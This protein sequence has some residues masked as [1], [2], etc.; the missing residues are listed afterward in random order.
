MKKII[1]LATYKMAKTAYFLKERLEHE[2][3]NC[4]LSY[5]TNL[6]KNRDEVRVQ[7]EDDDVER[8]IKTM[9]RIKD[10]YGKDIEMIEPVE[11]IR[12]IVVPTDFSKES[13]NAC[14]Y[15]LYLARKLRAEIKI[16]HVYENPIDDV[17]VRKSSSFE[18]Y[19]EKVSMEVEEDARDGLQ[20]FSQRIRDY[21]SASRIQDVK[22][23]SSLVMGNIVKKIGG[24]CQVYAPDFVVLGIAGKERGSKN[25]VAGL[26]DMLIRDLRIP[27]YAIPGPSEKKDLDQMNIL[28]A[29]D[30]NEQDH[31][32]LNQ[33]L[34]LMEPFNIRID[35]IHI[36]V[37]QNPV[38]EMRMNELN[39]FLSE[40]YS[41]QDIQCYL[42]EDEDVYHGIKVFAEN[43]GINLLSFT[44]H[45]RRIFEKLFKPNL[46]K[47]M[48]HEAS[49]PILIFPS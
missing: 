17:S 49:I 5:V 11:H 48:L 30:F 46:F 41:S 42:T 38:S 14:I 34:S 35:C 10:E 2:S 32:S 44:F 6:Q 23:H 29:T 12:K 8:A 21:M 18:E 40:K 26:A 33:L 25:I 28:Y 3:V 19:A 43:N 47:R 20:A 1:T 4:F 15:A 31:V 37:A 16:L 36:D 24:V 22:V 7:V 13:E 9:L 45:K 39:N 27:V